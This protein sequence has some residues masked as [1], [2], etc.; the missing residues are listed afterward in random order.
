MSTNVPVLAA[1]LRNIRESHMC[2]PVLGLPFRLYARTTFASL[3][4]D[5]LRAD[6][7]ALVDRTTLPPDGF[8]WEERVSS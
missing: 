2:D 7:S 8:P 1:L 4:A 3:I 5:E 6:N